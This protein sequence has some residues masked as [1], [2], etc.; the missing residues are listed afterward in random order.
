MGTNSNFTF[1]IARK[2]Q[3]QNEGQK[4]ALPIT[5]IAI[6]SIILAMVVN[7]ITI[8]VVD[9]F[10][11]EVSNKVTG[12]GSHIS[13]QKLG[14][15]SI[16]ESEPI[17]KNKN[18]ESLLQGVDDVTSLQS[19]A[20]I[21]AMLQSRSKNDQKEILGVVLKGVDKNYDWGFFKDYIVEGTLPKFK[22]ENSNEIL[23]SR[24]VA[25]DLHYSLNDTLNA[26]FVKKTPIQRQFKIVGIYETGLED[27]DRKITFVYLPQV[28]QLNSW[29]IQ[30]QIT[31]DDTLYNG[32]I[33]VRA[34]VQGGNGNLRYDWGDG[35]ERTPGFNALIKNDTTIRLIVSDYIQNIDEPLNV[36][37]QTGVESSIPDTCYLSIKRKN[38]TQLVYHPKVNSDGEINKKSL[39]DEGFHYLIKTDLGDL[40]VESFPGKGSFSNYISAYEVGVKDFD[41]LEEVKKKVKKLV[42]LNPD[43]QQQVSVSSIKE[44][45][46][47]LFTWL[48]FLDYNLFIVVLLML[49]IGVVNMGS[50]L[51]VII[52]VRTNFIGLMKSMGATNWTI[53]K[54]FIVYVG[55]LIVVGMFWGNLIGIGLCFIQDQYNILPLDPKVYYLNAVPISMNWFYFLV[56]NLITLFVC[57][58]VLLIPSILI[59]RISPAKSIKMD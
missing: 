33:I 47:E 58:L 49:V 34:D 53:R 4:V 12:F 16:M 45:E 35:W 30:S 51:L 22:D 20:Y 38:M 6:F 8:A 56:L 57:I 32:T 50:A 59:A 2:L 10:Q 27:F 37:D 39:D 14:E 36:L 23:I 1:F 21:P 54:I 48:D 29:G 25:T 28:Q 42:E 46:A 7:T 19:V 43:F 31:I 55:R 26:Y 52:M 17:Q 11:T 18:I 24:Q 41:H 5:R 9:G 3:Q 40:E 15:S 44:N 13:I